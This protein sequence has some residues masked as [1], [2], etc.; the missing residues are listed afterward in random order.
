MEKKP[1]PF[2]LLQTWCMEAVREVG[3]DWPKIR[4]YINDKLVGMPDP[5]RLEFL[6]KVELLLVPPRDGPAH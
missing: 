3:D 4:S 2:D 1:D 6:Q 5:Q